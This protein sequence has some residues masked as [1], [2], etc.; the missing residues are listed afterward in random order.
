MSAKNKYLLDVKN[1]ILKSILLTAIVAFLTV[2]LLNF[3][4]NRPI[5]NILLPFSSLPII[6][7]MYHLLTQNRYT[8]IIRGIFLAFLSIIYFPLAWLTSPGSYSAMP[9]YAIV[10]LFTT[11]I[12]VQDLWEHIFPTAIIIETIILLYYEPTKPAQ[13]FVYLDPYDR[14]LDLSLNFAI[15]S[16]IVFLI[17]II[18]NGYFANEHA[19][20][21]ET[22]ITDSLTGLYNRRYLYQTLEDLYS[23]GSESTRKFSILMMD[24]DN[25]KKVNDT[26]GHLAG[27]EV[28]HD[29]GKILKDNSRKIDIPVRYGGDEFALL[30]L[31]SNNDDAELV[32]ERI[33]EMFKLASNKYKKIDLSVSF[34]I[35]ESNGESFEEIIKKAD[36][37]LYKNKSKR[38]NTK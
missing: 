14:A 15:A 8:K 36:D 16:F 29:F 7:A 1:K 6:F 33:F 38:S 31:D 37:Y 3:A 18:L 11:M 32:K 19:R 5:L 24:L 30:L 21:F 23:N 22:S 28:L 20:I 12:L 35:C 4:N 9:F 26:F 13:Y 25:F 34:G 17:I 10:I 2:G 27:D